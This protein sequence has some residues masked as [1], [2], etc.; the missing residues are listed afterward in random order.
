MS[1]K[2]F[3]DSRKNQIFFIYAFIFILLISLF[4]AIS[5]GSFDTSFWKYLNGELDDLQ[6]KVLFQIRFPRVILAAFVGASLAFSGS[7]LQALFRNPLAD[8]GLI[9]V[10]SGAA[11][12][13]ATS[14]VLA[15]SYLPSFLGPFLLPFF[16]IA[17]SFL[18]IALLFVITKGFGYNGV[19]YMLLAGIAINA[20]AG[21]G[22]GILTYISDDVELRGLTFW[23][24]GSFGSA[25]WELITPA[26]IIIFITIFITLKESR[27]LDLIQLG[28]FEAARLGVDVKKLKRSIIISSAI[29]VGVSV[30]L[31]GMIGFVGLVVPHIIRLIGGVNHKYLL[32][33]SIFFGALIMVLADLLSRIIISPAELPVGLITSAIGAPFFLWLIFKMRKI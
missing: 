26:I 20:L 12:G 1:L 7:C 21:V 29:V 25:S 19:T 15:S 6:E 3:Y 4:I 30:S 27:K 22:I 2:V 10:S 17:G 16:A 14:I 11:L 8:P 13:A 5:F 18:V 33:G 24:M 31:T 28:E 9:G 23:T 32:K